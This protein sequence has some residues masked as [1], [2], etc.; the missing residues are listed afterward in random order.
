[1]EA[2]L[3]KEYKEKVIPAMQKEF[4]YKNPMQIPKLV[5][6]VIN[7]GIGEG[8][9]DKKHV[10]NAV[11]ELTLISGQKPFTTKA[12]KSES[13]FKIRAGMAIGC[14]VTLRGA[15]MYEFMDRLV[16]SA[17]PRIRDFRGLSVKS[18]DGR[19]NYSMG[20]KEQ[21]VFPEVS[22]DKID[23]VR[24]MDIC[25]VTTANTNEE[26]KSLLEGFNFPFKKN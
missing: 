15:R 19:G 5:K 9:L 16:N 25:V 13:G 10:T 1:M 12:K 2:R 6:I 23:N 4:S 22:Y 7:M 24:G 8:S 18:F 11:E 17:M 20:I 14:K 26:A 3:Y 21:I